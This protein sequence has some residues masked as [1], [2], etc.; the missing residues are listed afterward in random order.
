V[1]V[2]AAELKVRFPE[3]A[4]AGDALINAKLADAQAF[5]DEGAFGVTDLYERAVY[6]KAAHLLAISPFG[7]QLQLISDDGRTTYGDFYQNNLLPLIR[8]RMHISGGGLT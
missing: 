8:R 4:D 5:L 6:Y 1:A 3:F 2:T 7:A